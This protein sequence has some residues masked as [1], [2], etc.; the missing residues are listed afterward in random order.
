[1][2]NKEEAWRR[3]IARRKKDYD[4]LSQFAK[5]DV[6]N[7]IGGAMTHI[8]WKGNGIPNLNNALEILL[9]TCSDANGDVVQRRKAFQELKL[10][11]ATIDNAKSAQR[12]N[13]PLPV[14]RLDQQ[15]EQQQSRSMSAGQA[16]ALALQNRSRTAS[17][18]EQNA[19]AASSARPALSETRTSSS[20]AESSNEPT[21]AKKKIHPRDWNCIP[22][23]FARSMGPAAEQ[24][25]QFLKLTPDQQ[26]C[27]CVICL[28]GMALRNTTIIDHCDSKSHIEKLELVTGNKSSNL[29][30]D[31]GERIGTA[32]SPSQNVHAAISPVAT[33][34]A[35]QNGQSDFFH[36]AASTQAE[37]SSAARRA[38]SSADDWSSFPQSFPQ[39]FP[40]PASRR[41]E[42]PL[43]ETF[44]QAMNSG[45]LQEMTSG[46][47]P[48]PPLTDTGR[49]VP[50]SA[51]MIGAQSGSHFQ[52]PVFPSWPSD[53]QMPATQYQT[54][55]L[56]TAFSEPPAHIGPNPSRLVEQVQTI[57]P[58]RRIHFGPDPYE[59]AT[60]SSRFS[61]SVDKR[62]N[63]ATVDYKE[64]PIDEM[65]GKLFEKRL[66]EWDPY[67]YWT[68]KSVVASGLTSKVLR[69]YPKKGFI[70]TAARISIPA[71]FKDVQNI[72]L[73]TW[74]KY[75][76]WSDKEYAVILRMLPLCLDSVS[77]KRADCHYWPKGTFFQLNGNAEE[78]AQRREQDVQ[79]TRYWQGMCR[80]FV[81]SAYIR[82]AQRKTVIEI[83]CKDDDL[84]YFSLSVC[85]FIS[86]ERM[87]ERVKTGTLLRIEREE[88][89]EKA[90]AF[91]K[92][93]MTMSLDSDGEEVKGNEEQGVFIVNLMCPM[94]KSII[95]TP[96]RGRNCRHWQVSK[97]F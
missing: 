83:G 21:Q 43:T 2:E 14:E 26:E 10:L 94:S 19:N 16:T 17:T 61:L 69:C 11:L 77:A 57:I 38:F 40:Q 12:P 6:K 15:R 93:H 76:D 87:F 45:V 65:T 37:A 55:S 29:G 34:R 95:S 8:S 51:A 85:Q 75:K 7:V 88:A 71:G 32:P 42:I 27:Y 67:W 82:D 80:E 68:P 97:F 33:S 4:G 18:T 49:N 1:M 63:I 86:P 70:E 39:P 9:E 73:V 72:D 46:G 81:L 62:D 23:D 90:K 84:F 44:Q 78:I 20:A 24:A 58:N 48:V 30:S 79:G 89:T 96:V 56:E 47:N 53:P 52:Q 74:G 22:L 59:E 5:A 54:N 64:S 35:L 25:R 60:K 41:Q 66:R 92:K 13:E 31:N 28:K 50:S 91:A 36:P 3:V